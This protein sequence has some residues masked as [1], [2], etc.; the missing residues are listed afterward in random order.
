MSS[1]GIFA[2]FYD[3]LTLNA[4][5]RERADYIMKV[6]E[7]LGHNMGLTLDLACGTGNLTLEL[8]RRGVDIYG[9]D[10]SAEMLSCAQEKSIEENLGILFLC[11]QM[12][13]IDLYG[14][15]DTCICTLDSINHMTL[16]AD[17]R[18]TFD[19]V[20][21]FMNKNGYFFFDVNTLYK[22]R[23]VLANNTFV[24]DLDSVFCV[25]QNS[26]KENNIID[27]E[28]TFFE[29]DENTYFRTDESFSERAYSHEELSEMLSKAGFELEAVYG[30]LSFESPAEDEQRAIY[31][32]RKI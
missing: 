25:W 22:H 15:I 12:Q 11:Q 31:I 2:D 9:I 29:R 1:Y 27:I 18:K 7:R 23:N 17:V 19:R 32:A 24:Y 6:F 10:G 28:L 4:Q 13:S 8:A 26:L 21:L 14:T 3:E 20:S 5:Y 30:D 16:K